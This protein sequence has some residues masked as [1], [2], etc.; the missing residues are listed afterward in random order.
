MKTQPAGRK[1]NVVE[2]KRW[3]F[4]CHQC[5]NEVGWSADYKAARKITRL[6][7]DR[8]GFVIKKTRQGWQ[9]VG[10]PDRSA[11][12]P[13]RVKYK[14]IEDEMMQIREANLKR[15][16]AVDDVPDAKG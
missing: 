15:M 8:C 1:V 4:R 12:A 2:R 14:Q 10:V 13:W 3:E 9:T 11:S 5:G 16:G 6:E 7:C